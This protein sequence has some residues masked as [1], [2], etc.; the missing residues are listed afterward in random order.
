MSGPTWEWLSSKWRTLVE[1]Y[2]LQHSTYSA[3]NALLFRQ[4]HRF[5]VF[6]HDPPFLIEPLP[7]RYRMIPTCFPLAGEHVLFQTWFD[8][9]CTLYPVPDAW[10]PHFPLEE[11][12]CTQSEDESDYLY[13]VETLRDLRGRHLSSRRNL[14]HQLTRNHL[15]SVKPLNTKNMHEARHI[16]DAWHRQYQKQHPIL[17]TDY[18][19]CQE[20]LERLSSLPLIGYVVYAEEEPIGF[21]LGELLSKRVYLLHFKEIPIF[22]G[23]VPFLYQACAQAQKTDVQWIN[24]E[25]DLGIPG[26]RQAKQAYEPDHLLPKW[27]IRKIRRIDSSFKM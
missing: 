16:L 25:P 4:K 27:E 6:E 23:V 9:P 13:R 5:H 18:M 21:Y 12:T 24:L 3:A 1:E 26:L 22:H 19:P 15:L 20:A 10:L 17:E 2:A 11:Y 14:L 7:D 8:K